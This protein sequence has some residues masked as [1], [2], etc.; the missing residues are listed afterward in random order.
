MLT[1]LRANFL[2]FLF[3]KLNYKTQRPILVFNAP[4]SFTAEIEG[5]QEAEV[6]RKP[7]KGLKYGFAL[8]FAVMKK[9]LVGAAKELGPCVGPLFLQPACS[10]CARLQ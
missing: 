4:D 1:R 7:K 2:L 6:H 5:M 3:R 8:A 10:R 9:D